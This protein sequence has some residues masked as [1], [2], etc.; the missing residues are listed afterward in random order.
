MADFFP[1]AKQASSLLG[2]PQKSRSDENGTRRMD[3]RPRSA[4]R[5]RETRRVPTSRWPFTPAPAQS[6]Q[7]KVYAVVT[8]CRWG[9][10]E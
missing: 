9:S 1:D 2:L 10:R 7:A 5:P 3:A 6:Q 8:F 4:S